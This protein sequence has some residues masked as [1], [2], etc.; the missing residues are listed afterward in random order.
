MN[1]NGGILVPLPERRIDRDLLLDLSYGD[2]PDDC[3]WTV[4]G[5]TI[6]GQWRWGTEHE[7]VLQA[8]DGTYW[9]I[10]YRRT[11]GDESDN[12]IKDLENPARLYPML[13]VTVTTTQFQYM[14]ESHATP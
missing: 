14:K 13:P 6:T 5:H 1:T 9:G 3:G 10:N 2:E 8:E 7:L 12:D 11:T 4:V